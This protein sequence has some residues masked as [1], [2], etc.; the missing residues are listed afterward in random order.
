MIL[1]SDFDKTL[2]PHG[3]ADLFHKNL[4]AVR[5]FRETAGHKFV[6]ATGRSLSSILRIFPNYSGYMDYIILD[7]GSVC[8]DTVHQTTAFE[9][10]L[11]LTIVQQIVTLIRDDAKIPGTFVYYSQLTEHEQLEHDCTKLRFWT[12]DRDRAAELTQQINL[13]FAA[14]ARAYL[15]I[16]VVPSSIAWIDELD[17]CAF[18][19]IAPIQAGKENMIRE[20]QHQ[21]YPGDNNIITVG[22]SDNDIDMLRDFDGYAI[23]G[24]DVAALNIVPQTHI[25]PNVATLIDRLL[26]HD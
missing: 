3:N 6:L 17:Y 9:Y 10:Q 25:V 20:L 13:G 21:F 15:A 16:D 12:N 11:P 1:V 18:I 26:K 14:S 2:Y 19:D 8:Y 24:S 5:K 4:S 23:S 7:N 22:D